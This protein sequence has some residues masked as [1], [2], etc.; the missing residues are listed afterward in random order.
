MKS[1]SET[2]CKIKAIGLSSGG[3]D[4]IL[5]ALVLKREG[6][7][8][9]WV[10]FETP[11][12]SASKAK[13][14]AAIT[15]I[16]ITVQNITDLY[17]EM[18]KH[19]RFGYGKHM[20]PCLDCHTLMLK[21]AGKRMAE[22]GVHFIFTGEVIGQRPMSQTKPSLR[23]VEKAAGLVGYVLRPLSAKRL[24]VT[25]PEERGWV[26]REALLSLSGRS[27]KPQMA[28]AKELGITDYP[29]PA[30]G[31]LLTDAAF[32]R[33]LKDL[34]SH[35]ETYLERD[36]ELLKLGRHFRINAKSKIIVGRT[37]RD[38]QAIRTLASQKGD[39]LLNVANA[40]G[41]VALIPQE[42][43]EETI[44]QGAAA[45]AGYSKVP[46]KHET[47]VNVSKNGHVETITAMSTPPEEFKKYMI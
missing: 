31:C 29:A 44:R 26:N 47:A 2:N 15:G 1:T 36:F 9:T 21:I 30:G 35:Q 17:L 41:P 14:A 11:F 13:K 8:V 32:S 25:I 18:L 46:K 40:P 24:P 39:I 45:C 16:P 43:D 22:K 5:S 7:E 20:N 10:S 42:A 12:F 33:R 28:L 3:L 4:S 23:C 38:N 34:F 37:H 6:I 27:R 19:P